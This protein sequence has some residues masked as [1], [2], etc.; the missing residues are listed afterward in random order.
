MGCD[1]IVAGAVAFCPQLQVAL[2]YMKIKFNFSAERIVSQDIFLGQG[3][4][5][6]DKANPVLFI[7]VITGVYKLDGN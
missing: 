5:S 3:H 1:C 4:I 2:S 6:A 7:I